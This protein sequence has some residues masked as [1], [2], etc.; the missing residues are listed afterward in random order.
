MQQA[1]SLARDLLSA[2]AEISTLQT[3]NET[4]KAMCDQARLD[5]SLLRKQ[6]DAVD[7]PQEYFI[8]ML[9]DREEDVKKARE[10]TIDLR[11]QL[12]SAQKLGNSLASAKDKAE[13]EVRLLRD[14]LSTSATVEANLRASLLESSF[15]K[16]VTLTGP[17]IAGEPALLH[18]SIHQSGGSPTPIQR[19]QKLSNT[20]KLGSPNASLQKKRS[21]PSASEFVAVAPLA[22]GILI[23][24]ESLEGTLE[25]T[26]IHGNTSASTTTL[27]FFTVNS[28]D[29]ITAGGGG[30]GREVLKPV[31]NNNANVVVRAIGT[32]TNLVNSELNQTALPRWFKRS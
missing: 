6:L 15:V 1:I 12:S 16:A 17:P 22:E 25:K 26:R 10:E 31:V 29:A 21:D 9:R 20:T 3:R 14:K 2:K 27:N 32:P 24:S 8:H 5:S 19:S 18:S 23:N 30:G 4:L 7:G 28:V 11:L 13:A